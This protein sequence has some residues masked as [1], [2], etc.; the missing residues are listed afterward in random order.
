MTMSRK[1]SAKQEELAIRVLKV[2]KCPSNS[3]KATLTYQIGCDDQSAIYMRVTGNSSSGYFNRD[4]KA[5]TAIREALDKEGKDT[6]VTSHA[7]TDLYKFQSTNSPAFLFAALKA[8]GLVAVSKVKPRAYDKVSDAAFLAGVRKL[9]AAD[10]AVSS[11]GK[12]RGGKNNKGEI[13]AT[14]PEP[15][16]GA[17]VQEPVPSAE[18]PATKPLFDLTDAPDNKPAPTISKRG[19]PR[20]AQPVVDAVVP[21][22]VSQ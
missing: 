14:P 20:K 15:L 5:Y 9:M 13:I 16:A 17:V 8:E 22:E 2:A 18:T 11:A 7:L 21:A 10:K 4:W 12:A 3:G 6:P 1:K 19:R